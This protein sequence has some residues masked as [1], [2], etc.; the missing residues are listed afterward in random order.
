MDWVMWEKETLGEISFF[1]LD[2][3]GK[4]YYNIL[5]EKYNLLEEKAYSA[6]GWT[7]HKASFQVQ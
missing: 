7:I 3:V 5:K 1:Y 6:D 2:N 4:N